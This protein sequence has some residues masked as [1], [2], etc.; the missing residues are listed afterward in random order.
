MSNTNALMTEVNAGSQPTMPPATPPQM[1]ALKPWD[2]AELPLFRLPD[3]QTV[4]VEHASDEQFESWRLQNGI[5][6]KPGAWSF[7]RRCKAL[8]MCRFYG[9]WAALKFPVEISADSEPAAQNCADSA[10]NSAESVSDSPE[11]EEMHG[12]PGL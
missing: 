7:E 1:A 9:A 2:I 4:D 3:G 11:I 8:N 12:N 5:P 10:Q 6:A